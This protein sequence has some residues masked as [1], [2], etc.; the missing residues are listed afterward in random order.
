M[1]EALA[2]KHIFLLS[3]LSH[4]VVGVD[5]TPVDPRWESAEGFTGQSVPAGFFR[6]RSSAETYSRFLGASDVTLGEV[7]RS[8]KSTDAAVLMI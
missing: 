7:L 5:I 2:M 3:S 6:S 1:R 8:L 4:R